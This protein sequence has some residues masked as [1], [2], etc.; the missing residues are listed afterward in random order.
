MTLLTSG[1]VV[2]MP[3]RPASALTTFTSTGTEVTVQASDAGTLRFSCTSGSVR[4]NGTPATPSV[5]CSALTKV[6]VLASN[7]QDVVHLDDLDTGFPALAST[8]VDTKL[9][10][11]VVYASR[12]PDQITTGSGDD[13][14]V[15]SISGA[16]DTSISMGSGTSDT[17]YLEGT[18][19]NDAMTISNLVLDLS[20]DT[21]AGG[22]STITRP[23]SGVEGLVASGRGGND[24]LDASPLTNPM[25]LTYVTLSGDDGNDTLTS[26]PISTNFSGGDGTNTMIGGAS[27]DYFFTDSNTDLISPGGAANRIADA[28]GLRSGGRTITPGGGTDDYDVDL[29]RGDAVWRVR[30]GGT[31]STAMTTASLRRPGIQ[32]LPSTIATVGAYFD[33]G[34]Q[35]ADH[36][37]AD[38]VALQGDKS[39]TVND[40]GKKTTMIDI[41]IPTGAWTTGGTIGNGSGSVDPTT[42]G[43]GTISLLNVGPVSVHG[44]WTNKNRGWT[45]RVHRD[46]LFRFA[47]TATLDEGETLLGNGT[48]TRPQVTASLIDTDE[49]RGLDVDRVYVKFLRR[50]ADPGGR[51]SWITSLRNGKSLLKFRGQL[52]GSNE[53]FT[54]AGGTNA[55]YVDRA[56]ADVLGRAPDPG[57]RTYWINRLNAGVDR[58]AVAIAFMNN[59][60][61]R[62]FLVADQFLRFLDRMPT[63]GEYA[64]WEPTLKNSATGEQ[65]LVAFLA[66]SSAYYNRS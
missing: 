63:S 40:A 29:M 13:G 6:T 16:L 50:V 36:T 17:L 23:F 39:V 58:G 12:F 18:S 4:A 10:N 32:Q 66:N 15:L 61:P 62:R 33:D 51:S 27:T 64:T 45:H 30:Q 65:Q 34:S 49:Y 21:K 7:F 56:Y 26:G 47:S 20:V 57:G 25:N 22:G 35:P 60:E 38:I 59:T 46:L 19:G 42:A 52:V 54:K 11:D 2:A 53:Y 3:A 14:L 43:Y 5:S 24:T 55:A 37:L 48:V 1:L 44:P 31:S 9:D 8:Y 41:T 28:N